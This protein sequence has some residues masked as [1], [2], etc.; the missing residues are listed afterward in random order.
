ALVDAD[1]RLVLPVLHDVADEVV[2]DGREGNDAMAGQVGDVAGRGVDGCG[3]V[4]PLRA[5]GCALGLA[6]LV[7]LIEGSGDALADALNGYSVDA[8]RDAGVFVHRAL[9]DAV[10]S[11]DLPVW[12]EEQGG[13]V[14][15]L[16]HPLLLLRGER[17][18][19]G[20]VNGGHGVRLLGVRCRQS[21]RNQTA[22]CDVGSRRH[23][24]S[25][26]KVVFSVVTIAGPAMTCS[27]VRTVWS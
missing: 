23:P 7:A 18:A 15:E 5:R 24:G 17:L 2:Q 1:G 3:Q 16:R 20:L 6:H 9:G 26:R 12:T 8:L 21:C 25:T 19:L 13:L 10:G 11:H 22:P 4:A 27:G 14:H